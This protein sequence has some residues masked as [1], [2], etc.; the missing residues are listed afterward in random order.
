MKKILFV[1]AAALM[2]AACSKEKTYTI[3]GSFDVPMSYPVG[4]TVLTRGPITG[5]VYLLD[6]DGQPIDSAQIEDEKFFFS[7]IVNSDQPYFAYLVSEYAASIFAIEAGDMKAV[8]GETVTV[9]GASINDAISGLMESVDNI[10]DQL[11]ED[12]AAMQE[13]LGDSTI[14]Q[15]LILP[16]YTKYSE[17]VDLL[18]DS[19]YQANTDNLVGVFCANVK[20]IQ[21]QSAAE[22]EEMLDSYSDYV[23]NSELIQQ[24]LKYLKGDEA[25]NNGG[26]NNLGN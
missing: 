9:S 3:E 22:L 24:H 4:D 11:Y 21:A 18:V 15:D 23:K 6:L 17:Q 1:F 8:I 12:M 14:S 2:L 26:E 20:T 19:V 10:G 25:Q 16:I 13:S 7:G 5:Y